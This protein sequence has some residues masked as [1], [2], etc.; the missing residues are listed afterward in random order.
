MLDNHSDM[1]AVMPSCTPIVPY[2]KRKLVNVRTVDIFSRK[3]NKKKKCPFR[4]NMF[5]H[6]LLLLPGAFRPIFLTSGDIF[7]RVGI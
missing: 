4:N 1:C 5:A 3:K 2:R 6:N 7:I